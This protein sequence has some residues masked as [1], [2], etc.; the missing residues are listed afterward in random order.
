M[1]EDVRRNSL[2]ES[3]PDYYDIHS[4]TAVRA[5]QLPCEPTKKGLYDHGC[6]GLRVAAK[7][8]NF[9]II[10]GISPF[11]LSHLIKSTEEE[12][13]TYLNTW[14]AMYPAVSVWQ[15]KIKDTIRSQGYVE[16]KFGRRRRFD[17]EGLVVKQS[18]IFREGIN[19]KIQSPACDIYLS[20]ALAIWRHLGIYPI[21]LV[22]DELVYELDVEDIDVT[23]DYIS[24]KM[25]KVGEDL[26]GNIIPIPAEIKGDD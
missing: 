23:M 15:K 2:P 11:G 26:T 8:V 22:H 5:F 13:A 6:P 25:K 7:N 9:G 17:L 20:A 4:Q 1:I 18:T 16:T 14:Y 21:Q 3:D 24:W 10:Y 12:A 19:F